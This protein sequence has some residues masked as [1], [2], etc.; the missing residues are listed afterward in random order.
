MTTVHRR[1]L[2]LLILAA[3]GAAGMFLGPHGWFG[4]GMGSVGSA[5]LYAALWLLMIHLSRHSVEAFPPDASR[6]PSLHWFTFT[7]ALPAPGAAAG[8]VSN[9]ASR[10][11]GTNLGL[12]IICWIV[13][14]GVVLDER[15][16][17]IQ[18]AAGRAGSGIMAVL[19]VVLISAPV[20]QSELL[21]P[22]LRLLILANALIGPLVPSTLS[23]NLYS[24][25]R[26]RRENA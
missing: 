7:L 20:T 12:L 17:R 11:F 8:Q 5:V 4:I 22:W 24:V 2:F 23:E 21:A 3:S 18:R 16:L 26:Y 9:S 25:F 14:A 6:A 15:D 19:I 1:R 13:V 10:P